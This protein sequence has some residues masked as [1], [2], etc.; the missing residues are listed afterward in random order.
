M[1]IDH[2]FQ[3]LSPDRFLGKLIFYLCPCKEST[4]TQDESVSLS[5]SLRFV[6]MTGFAPAHTDLQSVPFLIGHT[7]ASFHRFAVGHEPAAQVCHRGEGGIEPT[8][9]LGAVSLSAPRTST[10]VLPLALTYHDGA[11]SPPWSKPHGLM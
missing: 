9:Q 7:A 3:I 1:S 5:F 4:K 8:A 11:A 2:A 10:V 6:A